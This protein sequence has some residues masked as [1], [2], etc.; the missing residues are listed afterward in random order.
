MSA[1]PSVPEP[2]QEAARRK[3]MLA[4]LCLVPLFAVGSMALL[5]K[6]IFVF[7]L[8]AGVGSI[9]I[10]I[11]TRPETASLLFFFITYINAPAVLVH[12]HGMP[13]PLA[14]ATIGLLLIPAMQYILCQRQPIILAPAMPWLAAFCG[15]QLLS[16]LFADDKVA[17]MGAV[18]AYLSEGL[19]LFLLVTNTVRT[20]AMLRQVTWVLLFAG[21]FMGGLVIFQKVTDTYWRDYLGFAQ[22][23]EPDWNSYGEHEGGRWPS[24]PIGDKNYFAQFLLLLFPLGLFRFWNESN[25]LFRWGALIATITILGGV[26]LTG[27]RGAAL[28][29]AA[30][31]AV[32]IMLRYVSWRQVFG[33]VVV[34]GMLLMLLPEYRARIASIAGVITNLRGDDVRETDT[35]VLGRLSEMA[36]ASLVF[37]EHPLLGVGPGN[38]PLHFVEKADLL[39]FRVHG[40]ERRAHCLYLEIAAETGVPGILVFVVVLGITMSNLYRGHNATKSVQD[41]SMTAAY[42]FAMVVMISTGMFLSFAYVRYSWI[43]IGLSSVAARLALEDATME[44]EMTQEDVA[45]PCPLNPPAGEPPK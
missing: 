11:L 25:R 2:N 41:K 31:G 8:V 22:V 27:S 38:F 34:S 21:F 18:F 3:L 20:R 16:T 36:A 39:G 17:A 30:T 9:A 44:N 28:G 5:T 42:L 1:S 6:N 37:C 19:L 4:V 43:I 15:I 33:I 26:G 14:A 12:S 40:E 24:G 7:A 10:V 29:F 13:A 35:A 32:M 23:S 45:K